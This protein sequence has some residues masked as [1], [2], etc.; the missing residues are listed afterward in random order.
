VPVN[1][2]TMSLAAIYQLE[3]EL[4]AAAQLPIAKARF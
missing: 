4:A 2:L 3:Q 1:Q